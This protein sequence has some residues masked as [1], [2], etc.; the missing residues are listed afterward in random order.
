[1]AEKTERVLKLYI[2]GDPVFMYGRFKEDFNPDNIIITIADTIAHQH[3]SK[4][5]PYQ[6]K[7]V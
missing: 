7:V 1:M 4:T 3:E 2:N 5:T 6:L